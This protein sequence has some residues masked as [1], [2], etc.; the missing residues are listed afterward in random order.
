MV[1]PPAV[2]FEPV[3]DY[4]PSPSPP[5]PRA[6]LCLAIDCK[7]GKGRTGS[8]IA[9][10]LLRL[11]ECATASEALALFGD[12]RTRNGR[13]VTIPSQT[14]FV[15]YY[16]TQLRALDAGETAHPPA[17][18]TRA[19]ARANV[20]RASARVVHVSLS[21]DPMWPGAKDILI[22]LH[23]AGDGGL[24]FAWAAS[25]VTE[26]AMV[27]AVEFFSPAVLC[28]GDIILK[29]AG[30]LV[31]T[32]EDASRAFA[33]ATD[34]MLLVLV[35]RASSHSGPLRLAPLPRDSASYWRAVAA[36]C[37]PWVLNSSALIV[38]KPLVRIVSVELSSLPALQEGVAV[39]CAAAS[40]HPHR[41]RMTWTLS[42][43]NFCREVEIKTDS[44]RD[45]VGGGACW[46]FPSDAAPV[47]GDLRLSLHLAGARKP[48][49]QMWI[50]SAFLPLP[51]IEAQR[52]PSSEN[53]FTS[54]RSG[55]VPDA[56]GAEAVDVYVPGSGRPGCR[57]TLGALITAAGP[58]SPSAPTLA[59]RS[60]TAQSA[61]Q[62]IMAEEISGV[63]VFS[64]AE[65]DGPAKDRRHRVWPADL[66]ARIIFSMALP[67]VASKRR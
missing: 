47:G 3:N 31:R 12:R 4:R 42:S 53:I 26:P 49:V 55:P 39:F 1:L 63:A 15:E 66:S 44:S 62:D 6:P 35:R 51:D 46:A 16:E 22:E 54:K 67:P 11:R 38:P 17:A 20:A 28:E 13:G 33:A 24:G 58:V 30:S 8:V 65:L 7:A 36:A 52:P 50:H 27:H 59:V 57:P 14:R 45:T 60:V 25:S 5:R 2:T 61:L 29:V 56:S 37:G 41:S 34:A 18:V 10:L 40:R 9:A 64:K 23:R 48:I 32:L 19:V 43:G 21:R